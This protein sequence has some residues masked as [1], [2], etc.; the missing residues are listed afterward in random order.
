[1]SVSFQVTHPLCCA[2]PHRSS[3]ALQPPARAPVSE[4]QLQVLRSLLRWE[5]H[6]AAK[7]QFGLGPWAGG[8]ERRG[9]RDDTSV[10]V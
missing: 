1:M 5:G 7:R 8:L 10:M 9:V 6:V 4:G 3:I 2:H